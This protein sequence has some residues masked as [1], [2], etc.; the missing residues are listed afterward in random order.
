MHG[1]GISHKLILHRKLLYFTRFKHVTDKSQ[2]LL[3]FGGTL[4]SFDLICYLIVRQVNNFISVYLP[5]TSIFF[6]FHSVLNFHLRPRSESLVAAFEYLQERV[7]PSD[8]LIRF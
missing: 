3:N 5:T 4:Y 1:I 2:Q 8:Y 6:C 7:G